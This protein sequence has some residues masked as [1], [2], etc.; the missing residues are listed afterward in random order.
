MTDRHLGSE[1]TFTHHNCPFARFLDAGLAW[2]GTI[3]SLRLRTPGCIGRGVYMCHLDVTVE[4]SSSSCLRV[5]T[6]SGFKT[7]PECE[8]P[9]HLWPLSLC[10]S[11][12]RADARGELQVSGYTCH[13]VGLKRPDRGAG[14]QAA[15]PAAGG[16]TRQWCSWGIF[17]I[18]R[19]CILPQDFQRPGKME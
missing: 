8:H 2:F 18:V 9:Q 10:E 6:D 5:R 4:M 19:Q 3:A 1:L 14:S 12:P 15:W 16:L 11:L 17:Q 7:L 13:Q